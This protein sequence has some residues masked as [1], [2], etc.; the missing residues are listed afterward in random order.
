MDVFDDAPAA[1]EPLE[2][3]IAARVF[4]EDAMARLVRAY[5][6]SGQEARCRAM[7]ERYLEAYPNG[8]HR[9]TLAS[10]AP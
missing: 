8:L 4:R 7:R 10:C 9:G 2:R 1:I 3:A 6:E 5:D